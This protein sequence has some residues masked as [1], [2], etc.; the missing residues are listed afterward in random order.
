MRVL[1]FGGCI[2]IVYLVQESSRVFVTIKVEKFSIFL[3]LRFAEGLGL[4]TLYFVA[5]VPGWWV[6][7]NR[8]NLVCSVDVKCTDNVVTV[9][10]V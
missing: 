4:S 2:E 1:V 8:L 7:K 5:F 3:V 10:L 9:C 6:D